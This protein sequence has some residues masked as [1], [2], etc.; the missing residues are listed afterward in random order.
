MHVPH[1]VARTS[2]RPTPR[3]TE[4][5]GVRG[6]R[7]S[8]GDGAECGGAFFGPLAQA[9]DLG[10]DLGVG[11]AAQAGDV[12]RFELVGE[13]LDGSA[14]VE[15]GED[16]EVVPGAGVQVDAAAGAD[17]ARCVG[18]A[19]DDDA[20]A[21]G[22]RGDVLGEDRAVERVSGCGVEKGTFAR[23]A[24]EEGAEE[25][26]V[27]AVGGDG[28]GGGGDAV[29]QVF[30]GAEAARG[31]AP[32]G[33]VEAGGEGLAQDLAGVGS[34]IGRHLAQGGAAP[35]RAARA[36]EQAVRERAEGV[37]ER[38]KSEGEIEVE[39]EERDRR[40]LGLEE[41][42]EGEARRAGAGIARQL[43]A[44]HG[45][46][47]EA[48]SWG[49]REGGIAG[50]YGAVDGVRVDVV[51]WIAAMAV[52]EEDVVAGGANGTG[53]SASVDG[54]AAVIGREAEGVEEDGARGG[55]VELGV[56]VARKDEEVRAGFEEG[57]EG[58]EEIGAPR[59]GGDGREG[60]TKEVSGMDHVQG[61]GA[62]IDLEEVEDVTNEGQGGAGRGMGTHEGGQCGG[63]VEAVEGAG[64][65]DV[66]VGDGEETI[67]HGG[68][69]G[70]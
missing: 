8:A 27:V 26:A 7:G 65:R 32:L 12:A 21:R 5:A 46:E 4:V 16:H 56:V 23:G 29:E 36:A 54:Q 45:L 15:A 10:G 22:A 70:E 13:A 66:E 31:G 60:A 53:G 34:L 30:H 25:E 62:G 11:G 63:L 59:P 42:D 44:V 51:P 20:G 33:F 18:V 69:K 50:G 1:V 9:G 57:A 35:E 48:G 6:A 28:A 38:G 49:Q 43:E 41:I 55:V 58:G 2:W 61:V 3:L 17:L 40:L 24:A 52:G 19:G 47:H 14:V 39:E 67:G 64:R 68:G 37:S